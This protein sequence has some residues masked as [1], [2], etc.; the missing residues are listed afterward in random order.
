MAHCQ[1]VHA[2]SPPGGVGSH[3]ILTVSPSLERWRKAL[4][5]RRRRKRRKKSLLTPRLTLMD[6]QHDFHRGRTSLLRFWSSLQAMRFMLRKLPLLHVF[7][8]FCANGFLRLR[9][10]VNERTYNWCWYDGQ[11][12]LPVWFDVEIHR[13]AKHGYKIYKHLLWVL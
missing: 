2:P 8:Y 11:I 4:H 10:A 6:R 5:S 9:K 7:A 13:V 12:A 1:V 3:I